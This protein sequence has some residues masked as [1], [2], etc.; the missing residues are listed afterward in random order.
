MA[1]LDEFQLAK[2]AREMVM[3]I[4]NYKAIFD[5]F[6]ITEE[7]YYEI[8]KNEFYKKAKSQ[9]AIEWNA[10][11]TTE[12][13]LRI[14]SLAYLE[15]LYPVITRKALAGDNLTAAVE[16]GKLLAKTAGIGDVKADK[17][18]AERFVIQINMGADVEKYDKP[19]EITVDDK[20]VAPPAIEKAKKKSRYAQVAAV[21][22]P[23]VAGD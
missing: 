18:L 10:T 4:R 17:N 8:E 1:D 21:Q 5:D 11:M 22:D 12:D 2:L 3:N 7:D 19:V 23:E 16:V 15:Q 20:P 14:G 9:F 6:G 13:R